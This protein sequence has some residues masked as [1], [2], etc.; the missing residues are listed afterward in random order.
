MVDVPEPAVLAEGVLLSGEM[1]ATEPYETIPPSLRMEEDG[2]ARP[3]HVH[4]RADARSPT[5]G[6]AAWWS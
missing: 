3:G 5:S 6:T 2:R 4:R 1:H